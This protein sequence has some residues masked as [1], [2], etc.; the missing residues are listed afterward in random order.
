MSEG[1]GVARGCDL[2]LLLVNWNIFN[3]LLNKR[4]HGPVDI[5]GSLWGWHCLCCYLRACWRLLQYHINIL[6]IL[7]DVF[8]CYLLIFSPLNDLGF[9]DNVLEAKNLRHSREWWLIRVLILVPLINPCLP[10]DAPV[11]QPL[12][13]LFHLPFR[14]LPKPLNVE[15]LPH[16]LQC[17]CLYLW[18]ILIRFQFNW[19]PTA[20]Y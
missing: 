1:E 14:Q 5:W 2:P 18:D 11:N 3:V 13:P 9:C 20:Y 15:F 8:D 4:S 16:L 19:L 7:A 10:Y 6:V 12:W 17:T